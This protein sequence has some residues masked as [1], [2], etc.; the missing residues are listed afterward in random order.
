MWKNNIGKSYCIKKKER[1]N[2]PSADIE[3]L[4]YC[5]FLIIFIVSTD[6]ETLKNNIH[7]DVRIKDFQKSVYHRKFLE[8]KYIYKKFLTST[9]SS[10]LVAV[11]V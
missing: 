5:Y 1:E 3:K 4:V 7:M 10:K 8:K 6:V 9:P 2:N 11:F